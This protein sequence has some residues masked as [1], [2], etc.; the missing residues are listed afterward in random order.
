MVNDV[1]VA[2]LTGSVELVAARIE[3]SGGAARASC[4]RAGPATYGSTVP[5]AGARLAAGSSPSLVLY[6]RGTD[7]VVD[8]VVVRYAHGEEGVE[9]RWNAVRIELTTRPPGSRSTCR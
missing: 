5:A 4:L 2:A 6:L 7:A 1:T 8:S 3:P 9:L